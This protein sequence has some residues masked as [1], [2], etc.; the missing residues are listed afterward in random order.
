MNTIFF[1]PFQL[2]TSLFTFSHYQVYR[3]SPASLVFFIHIPGW[4][5]LPEC[6]AGPQ[7]FSVGAPYIVWESCY[8]AMR[9]FHFSTEVL[10]CC[11]GYCCLCVCVCRGGRQ[12]GREWR[13]WSCCFLCEYSVCPS[14]GTHC[15]HS[16]KCT[17]SLAMCSWPTM[18]PQ[19][20]LLCFQVIHVLVVLLTAP[21]SL[22]VLS[23]SQPCLVS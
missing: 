18:N 16:P 12:G 9:I 11:P 21:A 2:Y 19:V 22:A 13:A 20:Y 3:Q 23:G 15:F 1:P 6:Q 14:G 5:H 7:P 4:H 8:C 17:F 10:C